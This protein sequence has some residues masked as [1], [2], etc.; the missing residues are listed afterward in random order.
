MSYRQLQALSSSK[1]SELSNTTLNATSIAHLPVTI[2]EALVP[3]Y[4]FVSKFLLESIG[5]DISLIVSAVA[6][7]FAVSTA[8]RY[9]WK[10]V[11][12]QL[13]VYFMSSITVDSEDDIH[14]HIMSWL[15]EQRMSKDS[16]SLMVKT[17]VKSTWDDEADAADVQLDFNSDNLINFSNWESRVPPRFEPYFGDHRFWH[18]GRFFMFKREQKQMFGNNYGHMSMKDGE[19]IT[20]T[21]LGRSTAPIKELIMD[22]RTKYLSKAK[23]CTVIRRA[24]PKDIRLRGRNV[25]Q[26]VATRP[27][28]P[29]DTVILD[30][31]QKTS[32]LS[33][34]NEYLHP[35]TPGWYAS[36]GIPYRRGY[37]LSGPP[38]CG[39][40]SLSF[41]IAGVFGLGIYCISLLEPTLTEEDLGVLFNNLPRRCVVLL[42]DID[43]AGL[44]RKEEDEEPESRKK[45]PATSMEPNIAHEVSRAI[46]SATERGRKE[47][48]KPQGISLSG[49]LNAID[50]VASHEGRVLIMTTNFPE[51]LDEALIRPG[52]VD[53]QI[54]FTLAS[55]AQTRELFVRMYEGSHGFDAV[56][57]AA[58]AKTQGHANEANGAASTTSNGKVSAP[59]SSKTSK[60]A[61]T[62]PA[63]PKTHSPSNSTSNSSV[64]TQSAQ[65]APTETLLDLAKTFAAQ[66]PEQTFSPAEIQGFLL[67]R[68]KEPKRAVEEVGTWRDE[69]LEMRRQREGRGGSGGAVVAS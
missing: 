42:E 4:S 35:A 24:A 37:L 56:Y 7:A 6:I 29:M 50:G 43:S 28:R 2:V 61:G 60:V 21:C 14:Q 64:K 51:R 26:T 40:S 65:P 15:A 68:K 67:T 58:D 13:K 47:D 44:N 48:S 45:G 12:A 20:L 39:K 57:A 63:T 66:L 46:R 62:P 38:G 52:R 34:I 3:G 31:E 5:L 59:V 17:G 53:M 55:K 8:L 19:T 25:W 49:L 27:S 30:P 23:A 22:T 11:Y 36:R 41:A 10:N 18:K 54:K 1:M 33:D 32:V 16:R 9:S 69:V